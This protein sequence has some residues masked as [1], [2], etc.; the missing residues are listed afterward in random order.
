MT[1][2][3]IKIR[4]EYNKNYRDN[5]KDTINKRQKEWRNNN[6]DKVKIYNSN[7]WIKKAERLKN[8]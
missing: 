2:D 7:Y 4:R 5:N 1:E 8:Q 6:K 3:A